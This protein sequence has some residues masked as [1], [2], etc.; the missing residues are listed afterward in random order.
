M[1]ALAKAVPERTP[2][3]GD[4]GNTIVSIGGYDDDLNAFA[5]VDLFAGAR[6]GRPTEDG[7][8]GVAHPGANISNTPVEIAEVELP[9][10]IEE[11]G[12]LRDTG[13]AG[14]FRGGLAQVRRV[15]SLAS[16]ATLQLRSDKRRFPPYGLQ[17]GE[18]GRGSWNVLNPGESETVLTTLG[19]A[20]MKR[21]DVILH[22]TASGGGWGDP[23]DRDPAQVLSDVRDDKVS[24]AH[25][26]EAYGVV[27]ND[28][29]TRVDTTATE[30]LRLSMRSKRGEAAR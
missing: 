17:G 6:G 15:K 22:T 11:Y 3:D 30:Q 24:A 21:G 16:E 13:G 2:A 26:N 12:M 10:R 5:F 27:L 4:G 18:P 28:N 7:P 19:T 8:E 9:V 29:A 14:M 20:T 23:L 1:A 25:A